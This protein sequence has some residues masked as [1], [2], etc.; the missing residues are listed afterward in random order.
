MYC[1]LRELWPTPVV[2]ALLSELAE[3]SGKV[4]ELKG[5]LKK[6][7]S[8]NPD[9]PE[10]DTW[11]AQ[12]KDIGKREGVCVCVCVCVCARV[13]VREEQSSRFWV[14]VAPFSLLPPRRI[15]LWDIFALFYLWAAPLR[16]FIS[17]AECA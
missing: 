16:S 3:Q 6:L 9:S 15:D 14:A 13:C 5:T 8:E 11:R 12:L 17:E 2:Q 1:M 7:I 10:V 4:E